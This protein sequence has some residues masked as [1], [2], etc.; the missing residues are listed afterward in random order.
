MVLLH[1]CAGTALSVNFFSSFSPQLPSSSL[2]LL[3]DTQAAF[4]LLQG[5]GFVLIQITV[6][7]E[8]SGTFLGFGFLLQVLLERL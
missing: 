5:N 8:L 1:G 6:V 3:A 7:G 2:T 4:Q